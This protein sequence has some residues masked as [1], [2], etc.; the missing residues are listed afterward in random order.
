M[1]SGA[2]E[3]RSK[4]EKDGGPSEVLWVG[5]PLPTKVDEEGL[6]HAFSPFGEIERVKTF[7]GRTYAFVQFK[8]KEDA[9]CAKENLD[10]KLFSDPRVHIRFSKSEIGPVD[11]PRTDNSN[12]PSSRWVGDGHNFPLENVG[13]PLG[14]RGILSPDNEQFGSPSRIMHNSNTRMSGLRPEYRPSSLM[15]GLGLTPPQGN[16]RNAE[17]AFVIGRKSGRENGRLDD[18]EYFHGISGGRPNSRSYDD[19]WDLPDEDVMYRDKKRP[20]A[21]PGGGVELLDFDPRYEP[22]QLGATIGTNYTGPGNV[23]GYGSARAS[24]TVDYNHG[25]GPRPRGDPPVMDCRHQLPGISRPSILDHDFI[26]SPRTAALLNGK[27]DEYALEG[28]LSEDRW[29]WHGT[30]A[31]GGTPVCRARCLPIGQGVDVTM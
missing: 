22:Q 8:C 6:L 11:N 29:Q 14:L 31:K 21:Y 7:P 23:G 24:A 26:P 15:S 12:L 19:T 30:I 20:R 17:V 2:G 3:V 28:G 1:L 13:V 25:L 9:I 10:G 18:V 5:F 16:T 27:R 4:V